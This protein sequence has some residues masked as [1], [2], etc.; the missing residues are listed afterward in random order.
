MRSAASS[1][2][3]GAGDRSMSANDSSLGDVDRHDVDVHVRHLLADDQH[4]D[5]R[6][7]STR[8]AARGRSAARPM[9]RCA[10][11]VGI[12]VDPVVDLVAR[13]D[14]HV[15]GPHRLDRQERDRRWSSRHTNR[16]GSSP[17]M[18][19]LK[20]RRHADLRA[21]LGAARSGWRRAR[22]R[23]RRTRRTRSARDRSRHGSGRRPR[24]RR[25]RARS[26]ATS[27]TTHPPKPA[28]VSR[29]PYA[30]A[31]TLSSTSR[32]SSGVETAK[33]SRS[34]RW[35]ASISAPR[36]REVAG[37]RARRR[38]RATRAFSVTTWR[39]IGS[40]A[41]CSIVAS[42]SVATPM[43]AAAAS[44]AARRSA[45]ALVFEPALE[46]AVDHERPRPTPGAG[47][48]SI[49]ERAAVEQQ[50]V[51]GAAAHRREL[52]HHPAR[53]AAREL[54]DLLRG[55]RERR[56]GR[57][58]APA[59]VAAAIA[60]ATANAALDDRPEP[61][62]T[63]DVIAASKPD[64]R[65]AVRREHVEHRR[66]GASPRRS[67]GARGRA[68]GRQLDRRRRG[69]AERTT[70]RPSVAGRKPITHVA[71]DRDRQAEPVL[72]VGVVA[73][74]VDPPGRPHDRT[75]SGRA[76]RGAYGNRRAR[77]RAVGRRRGGTLATEVRPEEDP[78]VDG[79]R[80]RSTWPSRR[81]TCC[82]TT[83]SSPCCR[84]CP[85]CRALVV[86]LV[87]FGP[88]GAHRR[89][90]RAGLVEAA[91]VDPRRRRL[92]RAHVRRRVL[93]RRARVRG[94]QAPPRRAGHDRRGGARRRRAGARVAAVG[95]R[96]RD[97]VARAAR[98]RGARRASSAASSA[99]SSGWRGRS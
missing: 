23:R 55:E 57:A 14:E 20:M 22:R 96:E 44:H 9:N 27:A 42:R 90:R 12:E 41:T 69:R 83:R 74:E 51:A 15:A 78:W 37:A 34:E 70:T 25:R 80:T 49:V 91:R 56:S 11:S 10:A 4:A 19:R 32:S 28:P 63:V 84:C 71:V 81:G 85:G 16:P 26:A 59:T 1:S 79:C 98:D 17:A 82:A 54:L 38:T 75:R 29:A 40:S 36:G 62:G 66:D 47:P 94:R 2:A 87:F 5:P 30:P 86:A 7:G 58:R 76:R 18:M 35:L 39:A 31:S 33:S 88:V 73:D 43:R 13:H 61:I 65:A 93:Q 92:P 3:S 95:G 6:A 21:S 53:H 60:S 8:A 89:Q 52:V 48:A 50:R 46:P 68:V 64:R 97:R 99:R 24:R 67:T 72:V 45:Y 77:T